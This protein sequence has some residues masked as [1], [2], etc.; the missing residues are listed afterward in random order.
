[1]PSPST[2]QSVMP[3]VGGE[4]G[5][6]WALVTAAWATVGTAARAAAAAPLPAATASFSL[7]ERRAA[8]VG[9][10]CSLIGILLV[11]I[12]GN[13]PGRSPRGE[14][15]GAPTVGLSNGQTRIAP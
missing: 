10:C 11:T 1:V 15:M 2:S 4:I 12:L 3:A 14:P 13:G 9:V 8:G 6:S 5:V 7:R